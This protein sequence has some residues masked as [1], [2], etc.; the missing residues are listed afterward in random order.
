VT[1]SLNEVAQEG[2]AM[3][4]SQPMY[5]YIADDLRAKIRDG[6]SSLSTATNL[7]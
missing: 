2:G 3:P 1:S 5:R 4:Q 7:S 6:P